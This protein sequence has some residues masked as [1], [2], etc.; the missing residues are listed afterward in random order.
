M[1]PPMGSPTPRDRSQVLAILWPLA[2]AALWGG[3]YVVSKVSFAS[4][5]PLTLGFLRLLIGGLALSAG[6]WLTGGPAPWRLRHPRLPLLGLIL[7]LTLATQFWGTDLA[8][9]AYG[10]VLTSTTPLFL[11][12]L[13]WLLLGEALTGRTLLALL[14]GTAGLLVVLSPTL[15]APAAGWPFLLGS[16]L[17]L[18]A[19][20]FWALYS[21]LGKPLVEA[22][23]ALPVTAAAVLWSLPFMAPA[24]PF[25]LLGRPPAPLTLAAVVNLLYLGLGATALAWWL[26]YK[27][28]ERLPAR[29]VALTFFAQPVVGIFLSGL[30]LGEP[31]GPGFWLGSAAILVAVGLATLTPGRPPAIDSA[32][33][34]LKNE[35]QPVAERRQQWTSD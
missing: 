3:M 25:E 23:G 9:A 24:V 34:R 10:A 12:L 4:L 26:W 11:V 27:G 29:V 2:A 22:D 20:A 28:L 6:L 8:T 17:L 5:P 16:L 18:L 14:L 7:A 19:A 35:A 15:A 31:L 33:R 1:L 30:L 13:A 21:V 32:P